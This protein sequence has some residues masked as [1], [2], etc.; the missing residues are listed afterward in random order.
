MKGHQVTNGMV[1]LLVTI[2]IS[3]WEILEV[4]LRVSWVL[5]RSKN[6]IDAFPT[7][8]LRHRRASHRRTLYRRASHRR[9]SHRRTSPTGVH[10]P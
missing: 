1:E 7:A 10:L 6:S 4:N 3:W 8:T 5:L 2:W 9:A